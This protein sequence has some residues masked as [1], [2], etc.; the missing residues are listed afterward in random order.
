M[1]SNAI[2]RQLAE[3]RREVK[4]RQDGKDAAAVLD[5]TQHM[6]AVYLP[7]HEDVQA[8]AHQYYNLP[9]GRGSGKSSFVSLEI[10]KR[11]KHRA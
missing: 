10:V 1:S 3:I 2:A 7:L 11:F 6:A 8:A 4:R 5:V 9:G